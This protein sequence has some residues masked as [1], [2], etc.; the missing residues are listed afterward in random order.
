[1]GGYTK[2]TSVL[3][4]VGCLVVTGAALEPWG[5]EVQRPRW[6]VYALE[7][8]GALGGT[9][10][11]GLGAASPLLLLTAIASSYGQASDSETFTALIVLSD[12]FLPPGAAV[13]ATWAGRSLD[14]D[15]SLAVAIGG[16]YAGAIV[17][18]GL[19]F[20]G[21]FVASRSSAA[22]GIPFYVLG[23][24]AIPAGAVAGY[25][26]GANREA[27]SFSF[28]GR[29]QPP[30]VALMSVELPDHSVEYGLKVQLAG[31]RF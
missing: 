29:L 11:C 1:M 25:N 6:Q 13:G 21:R 5:E 9:A 7:G 4:A 24:L 17:G 30:G 26:L 10:C 16:A 14:E 15:G 27:S 3:I 19:V 20:T 23:G 28:G 22:A 31:L 18:T 8:I 12:V 2:T